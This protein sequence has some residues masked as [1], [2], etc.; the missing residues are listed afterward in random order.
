MEGLETLCMAHIESAVQERF[1]SKSL[2]I[3]RVICLKKNVEQPTVRFF[4]YL[5]LSKSAFPIIILQQ[6][7]CY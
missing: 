2:R 3:F 7:S 5:T 6:F 1:G 4:F